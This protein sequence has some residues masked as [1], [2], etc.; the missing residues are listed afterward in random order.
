MVQACQAVAIEATLHAT[1]TGLMA[2]YLLGH[3]L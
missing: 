2:T 3:A 1:T